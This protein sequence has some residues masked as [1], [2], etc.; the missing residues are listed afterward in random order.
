MWL[1]ADDWK[2]VQE[3]VPVVCVDVTP[4]RFGDD[5]RAQAIGLILRDTPHQGRR[6]CL[7]GGRVLHNESLADAVIRHLAQTLGDAIHFHIE[8]DA[9]PVYVAQYFTVAHSVGVVDPRQHSVAMNYLVGVE[10]P[11]VARGE[12]Y[13]FCWFPRQQLPRPQELGFGQDTILKECLRRAKIWTD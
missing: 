2:R 5:G 10:G 1:N 6:W 13:D 4:V 7:V 8:A 11:V 9:Q 12:A 3:T